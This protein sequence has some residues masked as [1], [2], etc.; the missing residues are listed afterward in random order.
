VSETWRRRGL[1]LAGAWNIGG[2]IIA[3]ADPA[4]HFA[5]LYGTAL[6]LTDPLQA[7]FFRV[8]WINVI[9]WGVGYV[10]AGRHRGARAPVLIAGGAGKLVYF[11]ACVSLVVT[12]IGGAALLAAG[13]LDMLF[14]AFFA[15]VLW[16]PRPGS[17]PGGGG[18]ELRIGTG[19]G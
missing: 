7:F 11:A 9:A 8:T 19:D 14:V 16:G 3:L 10:L 6:S 15:A 2:G 5:Q 1:Y 18:L 12:G 17:P 4:R 13:V